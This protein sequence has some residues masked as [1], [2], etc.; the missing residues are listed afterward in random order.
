MLLGGD[1]VVISVTNS[2]LFFE[3][4]VELEALASEIA[5]K[6][7]V[8]AGVSLESI[9][10]TFFEGEI[11]EEADKQREFFFLIKDNQAVLQPIFN[12]D[13][14][15][16][17]TL[18]EFEV[19]IANVETPLG[20]EQQKCIFKEVETRSQAIGDPETLDPT[21]VEFYPL[22]NGHCWTGW[23]SALY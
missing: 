8:G 13:T 18:A 5:S 14:T 17:I 6:A 16:P 21:T 2:P 4:S 11:S 19:F 7:I 3:A 12:F 20:E 15:G 1:V 9:S 23:A 22:N 10:I